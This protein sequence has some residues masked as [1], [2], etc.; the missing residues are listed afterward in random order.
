MLLVPVSVQG[1]GAA[2][3]IAAAINELN[4]PIYAIDTLIVGRGGGSFED[5]FCFS[6]EP[7]VRA[8]FNSTIPV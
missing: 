3:T 7:V 2:N 1:Q 6:E 4:N 5:L 8:I